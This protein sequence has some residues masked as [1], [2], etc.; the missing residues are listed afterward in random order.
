LRCSLHSNNQVA[1]EFLSNARHRKACIESRVFAIQFVASILKPWL[2]Y[3]SSGRF[4]D[5]GGA[6]SMKFRSVE[7][8]LRSV[9]L[10]QDA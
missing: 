1:V 8:E 7:E 5:R 6:G 2:S 3:A 10:F 4:H 9:F